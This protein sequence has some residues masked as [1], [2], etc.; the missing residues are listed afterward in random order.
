MSL[1]GK[2][3]P[4]GRLGW[5]GMGC[6][7][8]R[9][10]AGAG[11]TLLML[12][13][14]GCGSDGVMA[15]SVYQH[16]YV[17]TVD[18]RDSV[19]QA[20]A[21]KDGRIV[22]VGDDAGVQAY[23]GA[24]TTV[25]DLSGRMLMPGLVDGHMH[26]LG[27]G[28]QLRSCSLNYA[29]LTVAETQAAIQACLDAGSDQEP[30]GWLEVQ[31]WF[32]Q[33]MLP[34]GTDLDKDDL[35][36]LSTTRPIVV[37]SSDHHTLL[38]NSRAMALAGITDATADP[39]DGHIAHDSNGHLTGIFEDGASTLITEHIP[40][41][42]AAEQ[43]A[44][45]LSNARA[46]LAALRE[47]GIT[48]FL[49]A[50]A[51]ADSIAAFHALA[52]NG[53]L[54]ARAHFAPVISAEASRE[55]V[56]AVAAVQ[57]LASQYD[58]GSLRSTPGISVRNAKVFLDGVIQ[59]PAMTAALLLPYLLNQ[60]TET[61]PVWVA[62]SN[63]GD[64]YAPEAVLAPLLL[65]LAKAGIDPHLHTD[66]DRA[67]QVALNAVAI[68]RSTYPLKDIRPALAHNETVDPSDYPRFKQL[69]AIPVLSFQWGKPAPDTID[70]VKDY[71][72]AERFAYL[73]TSGRFQ[74]AG[75]RI[76]YGS[77]WPVDALDE[78]FALKVGVTRTNRPDADP[79]Y[80]GRLGTDPGLTVATVL[81]AIT[82]NSS[83]LLHQDT[84]L[85]S[86]EPGK[87]ADLIVLDR[88]VLQIQNEDIA[89]VKVLLTVVGGK[90]V[91]RASGF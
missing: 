68:V 87:F 44:L 10:W 27:G 78:W 77:D 19:Q 85:G 26:P 23:I 90:P 14:G 17:Y 74:E 39:L 66:G 2:K 1:Q 24:S 80:A 8:W 82:Q 7:D 35:D 43:I 58:Q 22:Y 16:G 62:G 6:Q 88:N 59:A 70:T 37:V 34:T 50:A 25:V 9:G 65:E 52:A 21:V 57:S 42:T 76:A 30:D 83:Y 55:P 64:L 38:A 5:Q 28:A 29:A 81:R 13:L 69:N 56:S 73:E 86:L 63:Y 67:V 75:A 53:E 15:D 18:A 12:A 84:V 61:S 54:T 36:Q 71:I 4:Q 79:K 3:R 47:Q 46:A 33:A 60:G 45:N 89:N 91:Y 20:L 48:S 40:S 49:D 41:P 72:G 31:A 32:R 51:S 11:T